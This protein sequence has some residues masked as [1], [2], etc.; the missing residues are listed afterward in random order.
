MNT[1][2]AVISIV[3]IVA[4][5]SGFNAGLL[6]SAATILGYVCAMP[7][8]V[9]TTSLI[10]S[11]LADKSNAPWAQSS[12]VP[13]GIF[14]ATGVLLANL[15]RVVVSETVGPSISI[16]D[17]LAGSLLGAVRVALVAVT[18]VLIFDRLIPADRFFP[19][20][21]RRGSSPCRRTSSPTLIS[22]RKTGGCNHPAPA[23]R[24]Q[25]RAFIQL[26]M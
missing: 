7:V 23:T 13:F 12:F 8:A 21:G 6:R 25:K 3:A 18:V 1:F 10:S 26:A 17:R 14:L 22:S 20:L 2:D 19:L 24:A 16:P 5:I 15:L 11:A 9:A 4:V